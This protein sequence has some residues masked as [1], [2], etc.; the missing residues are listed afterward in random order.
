MSSSSPSLSLN[1]RKAASHCSWSSS[2][3]SSPR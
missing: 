1:F 3:D 2:S